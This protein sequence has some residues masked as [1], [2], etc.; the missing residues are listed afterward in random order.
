MYKI[1]SLYQIS[2]I[3]YFEIDENTL[4]LTLFWFFF[5]SCPFFFVTLARIS[6]KRVHRHI[7]SN[8]PDEFAPQKEKDE[9]NPNSC[10]SCT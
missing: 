2:P 3:F 5:F 9:Q 8:S 7:C 6:R 1:E 10:W 4:F